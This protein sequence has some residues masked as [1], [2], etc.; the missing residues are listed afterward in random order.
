MGKFFWKIIFTIGC[1]FT[2][3]P[4]FA[5]E[6]VHLTKELAAKIALKAH[7]CFLKQDHLIYTIAVL[8]SANSILAHRDG[9]HGSIV[10]LFL[11]AV[12]KGAMANELQV[13]NEMEILA[14]KNGKPP[15]KKRLKMDKVENTAI[16]FMQ[17]RHVGVISVDPKLSGDCLEKAL[18]E[19]N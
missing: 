5:N 6:P 14:K 13:Q 8:D 19:K 3:Q 10:G 18:Q 16:I 4:L 2:M 9:K 1:F 17:N 15:P 7:E 12:E 11:N